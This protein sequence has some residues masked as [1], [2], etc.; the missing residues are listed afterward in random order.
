MTNSNRLMNLFAECLNM[1]ELAEDSINWFEMKE[2]LF[3]YRAEL[4][5][6]KLI[7]IL[8]KRSIGL[9][10]AE[11]ELGSP[12]SYGFWHNKSLIVGNTAQKS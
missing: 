3:D 1:P 2:L 9:Y 10:W 7:G 12:Q 5:W 8:G 11:M 6:K 4:F